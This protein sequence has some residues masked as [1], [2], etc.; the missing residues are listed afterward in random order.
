VTTVHLIAEL[1]K[2]YTPKIGGF[3]EAEVG[4]SVCQPS[5]ACLTKV[6]EG[7]D[8]SV[9]V[10]GRDIVNLKEETLKIFTTEFF[11]GLPPE[12]KHAALRSLLGVSVHTR[13]DHISLMSKKILGSLHLDRE[14]VAPFLRWHDPLSPSA[15]TPVRKRHRTIRTTVETPP[16]IQTVVAALEML[17]DDNED[18]SAACCGD[19]AALLSSLVESDVRTWSATIAPTQDDENLP[20]ETFIRVTYIRNAEHLTLGLLSKISAQGPSLPFEALRVEEIVRCTSHP[21]DSGIRQA[22]VDLLGA[23]AKRHP[24]AVL[25]HVLEVLSTLA[26][27]VALDN[28]QAHRAA[29]ECLSAIVPIWISSSTEKQGRDKVNDLLESFVR[30]L[31][32]SPPHR[33]LPLAR[34]CVESM[35]R[36]EG[37]WKLILLLLRQQQAH[38][39][40]EDL[41]TPNSWEGELAE[42]LAQ[43]VSWADNLAAMK[44]ILLHSQSVKSSS[45]IQL[46][47]TLLQFASSQLRSGV[48]EDMLLAEITNDDIATTYKDILHIAMS[49]LSRRSVDPDS[50]EQSLLAAIL[51][52]LQELMPPKS[53]LDGI[54][55]LLNG[56]NWLLQKK[57][58]RLI[59]SKAAEL[60]TRSTGTWKDGDVNSLANAYLGVCPKIC[61]DTLNASGEESVRRAALL[62]V[63]TIVDAFA[64]NASR[65]QMIPVHLQLVSYAMDC[66]DD[67]STRAAALECTVS[68]VRVLGTNLMPRLNELVAK[69]IKVAVDEVDAQ[70]AL[71]HGPVIGDCLHQAMVA[72]SVLIK[73]LGSFLSPHLADL[74]HLLL[75][76]QVACP[77]GD[78][79]LRIKECSRQ[80]REEL[81]VALVPRILLDPVL[82]QLAHAR[83]RG[84]ESIV[85]LLEMVGKILEVMDS[86]A[87]SAYHVKLFD[88][89]LEVLDMRGTIGMA[90]SSVEM[91]EKCAVESVLALCLKLNEKAF[92]PIFLQM[93][94]WSE[95][96][97]ISD[98]HR[99]SR[100][101]S[102]YSIV[103]ALT[104][105]LKNVFVPYF[106]HF[107][108][109]SI[110]LLCSDGP[111]GTLNRKHRKAKKRKGAGTTSEASV[112]CAAASFRVRCAVVRAF[113]ELF[114]HDTVGGVVLT[115]EILNKLRAAIVSF[116]LEL[117]SLP[118]NIQEAK[119]W[120]SCVVEMAGASGTDV[121]WKVLNEDLLMYTRN[122]SAGTRYLALEAVLEL[123][124]KL[125]EDFLVLLP[126]TL[127][128]LAELL[129]D[130]D[131][132]VERK[133]Q[134]IATA[135]EEISG[136][137]LG[138]YMRA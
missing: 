115:E 45:N 12:S 41:S 40:S 33:R 93:M 62:C 65:E 127:P 91:I 107:M 22:A 124:N 112:S 69:L 6:L 37:V 82:G 99:L 32:K 135:L 111:A 98:E 5:L 92:K 9:N 58:L 76:P 36:V 105:T 120:V 134:E 81:A 130:S 86:S 70:K 121:F 116:V 84:E 4:D 19:L 123:I 51:E 11:S 56:N 31:E 73:S 38:R 10:D 23:V 72:L 8:L 103:E 138:E 79:E 106:S 21:L 26:L 50:I 108:D 78:N 20:S 64:S 55:G 131:S 66:L 68:L 122:Q 71:E 67:G 2:F 59:S 101:M 85:V 74:L 35:P 125:R 110:S 30:C 7:P 57:T 132:G 102:F 1:L 126:E 43:S 39:K 117:S 89:L 80:A 104:K 137:D 118:D 27:T 44:H 100:R 52:S 83:E 90:D 114:V 113:R 29:Q 94:V 13:T 17:Q 53:F 97:Q 24:T 63:K 60:G 48:G 109:L 129:E 46:K 28:S 96:E 77:S 136:E 88:F 49:W 61:D 47:M 119:D 16:N 54:I 87:A 128:F 15:G 25:D 34:A 75:S 95:S 133:A 14:V 42:E 18:L 3:V